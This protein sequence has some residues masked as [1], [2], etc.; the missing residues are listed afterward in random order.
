M[1]PV[2]WQDRTLNVYRIVVPVNGPEW[3]TQAVVLAHRLGLSVVDSGS[4]SR[5][6]DFWI[7]CFPSD[8]WANLRADE[9]ADWASP[10]EVWDALQALAAA[11]S[12]A[13]IPSD[14]DVCVPVGHENLDESAIPATDLCP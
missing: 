6:G 13:P 11:G 8:D 7:G 3:V 1:I 12:L 2:Y 9:D 10:I 4:A 5:L 14:D